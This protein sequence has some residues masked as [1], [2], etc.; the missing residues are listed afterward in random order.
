MVVPERAAWSTA[1]RAIRVDSDTWRPISLI[2]DVSCSVEAATACT[3]ADA[4]SEAAATAVDC[5]VDCEALDASAFAALCRL[6]A[7]LPT[8]SSTVLILP[9]KL[10]IAPETFSC[11]FSRS[12]SMASW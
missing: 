4:S 7:D 1:V 3:F 11:R 10:R 9:S 6:L 8:V 12:A 5:W 2:D